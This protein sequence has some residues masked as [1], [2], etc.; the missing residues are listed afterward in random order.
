MVDKQPESERILSISFNQDQGCFACVTDAGIRIYNSIPYKG[1][2]KRS[3]S[4][5]S[6]A[7]MLY[8]TNILALVG[9]GANPKYPPNKVLLWDDRQEK[10]V[11]EMN[12]RG[13]VR[14]VKLRRERILVVLAQ[15]IYVYNFG[16]LKF[17]KMVETFDNPL[18]LCAVSS[19]NDFRIACPS[20]TKGFLHII[21]AD[22]K[23]RNVRAHESALSTISMTFD[24]KMCATT[25]DKGTLIRI[26]KSGD[27]KMIQ[28]LRRGTDK[29]EIQSVCFDP[30]GSWL[31][32]SSDKGTIHVFSVREASN[33]INNVPLSESTITRTVN[34]A[35]KNP[36]SLFKF[37]KG[38]VPYFSSEW[39]FAQFRIPHARAVVGFGE[40]GKPQ[41]VVVTY[42][43]KYYRAE[44]D[45]KVGGECNKTEE[46]G[47]LLD[48]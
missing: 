26:F 41:I 5:I 27:G 29:A 44:F 19:I 28:E 14:A 30:T 16:D 21:D 35:I 7:A 15:R 20:K 17:V 25:S 23:S 46:K 48:K 36:T 10:C 37:M 45:P 32:C 6:S 24:G 18:G 47:L 33:I 1:T 13:D 43:G 11:G 39:S 4:G 34:A 42:D 31:A 22:G 9:S 38:L 2:F 12:F 8:R 40:A 3:F